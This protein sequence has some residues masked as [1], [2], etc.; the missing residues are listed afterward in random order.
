MRTVQ[1]EDWPFDDGDETFEISGLT[2]LLAVRALEEEDDGDCGCLKVVAAAAE[3]L[4][5]VVLA[6]VT[7]FVIEVDVVAVEIP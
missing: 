5:V 7:T 6:E 4:V 1:L 2:S 3:G